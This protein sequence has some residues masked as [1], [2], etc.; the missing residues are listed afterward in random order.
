MLALFT[1]KIIVVSGSL[2]KE[3]VERFQ[4]APEKKFTVIELGLELDELFELPQR[5]NSNC[6]NIGIVGRLTPIK[7]HRMLFRTANKL[8]LN[9]VVQ[10]TIYTV[11]GEGELRQDLEN[12]AKELNIED[13]VRFMGWVKDSSNI[14]RELDIVVLTSLNEGTPVSIIEAMAAGRPVVATDVGG[15]S[16]LVDNEKSGY[17]VES[18]NEGI[19]ADRLRDLIMNQEKR[20]K[21]GVKAKELAKNRFSKER[22]LKDTEKLYNTCLKL[23][24]IVR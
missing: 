16:D 19:F 7:N 8:R 2:K 13:I 12:Y 17:L 4:I 11:I 22:L 10:K 24:G 3:L 1:D 14:Y 21:F 5:N 20:N 23:E 18:D 15:V 9:N 6:I